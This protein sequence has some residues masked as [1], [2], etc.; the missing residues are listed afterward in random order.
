M[1]APNDLNS[2]PAPPFKTSQ[3]FMIYFPKCRTFITN[4]TEL[5]SR[6]NSAIQKIRVA[7]VLRNASLGDFVVVR[8]S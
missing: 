8:T 4:S 6:K 5:V 3:A 1:I 7:C 2:S